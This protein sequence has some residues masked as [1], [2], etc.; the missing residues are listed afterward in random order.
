M[1]PK[2]CQRWW[3]R[4]LVLVFVPICAAQT[5]TPTLY[6]YGSLADVQYSPDGKLLITGS[7][8]G[9]MLWDA[10]KR[11]VIKRWDLPG[12]LETYNSLGSSTSVAFSPDGQHVA[13]AAGGTI[14]LWDA[15][16]TKLVKVYRA[17]RLRGSQ[18]PALLSLA[19]SPG[20]NVVAAGA[21][22]GRVRLW[23]VQDG[24]LEANLGNFPPNR[25]VYDVAFSPDGQL[26]AAASGLGPTGMISHIEAGAVRVWNVRTKKLIWGLEPQT[27]VFALTFSPDGE[28]LAFGTWDIKQRPPLRPSQDT[29]PRRTFPNSNGARLYSAR[30]GKLLTNYLGLQNPV[31]SLAFS[32]DGTLLAGSATTDRAVVWRVADGRIVA[33]PTGMYGAMQ[34]SALSWHPDGQTLAYGADMGVRFWNVLRNRLQARLPGYGPYARLLDISSDG[35]MLAVGSF[36]GLRMWHIPSGR[37]LREIGDDDFRAARFTPDGK[38]LL[39]VR[40]QGYQGQPSAKGRVFIERYDARRGERLASVET[41][42]EGARRAAFSPDRRFAAVAR[43]SFA[44][45]A[46]DE[47]V[48][49]VF[50]L[51]SG[52]RLASLAHVGRVRGNLLGR[53]IMVSALA[54]SHDGTRLA[55]S[56]VQGVIW[57]W[58]VPSGQLV[59]RLSVY[60]TAPDE[61][62][63]EAIA[64]HPEGTRLVVGAQ[65][66]DVASGNLLHTLHKQRVLGVYSV[67]WSADGRHV[68]I[69]REGSFADGLTIWRVDQGAKP[70]LIHKAALKYS[71]YS[72]RFGPYNS[73][74]LEHWLEGLI[75]R[76]TVLRG[77]DAL[78]R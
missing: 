23:N 77:R 28:T 53:P 21:T 20:G 74:F 14:K 13:A 52:K 43:D 72:A 76:R 25:H 29:R 41:D 65:I 18:P 35:Q 70:E 16:T 32:P 55:V 48:V 58:E 66:Y 2:G 39:V 71:V 60:K 34:D 40:E 26:L 45:P 78:G 3:L 62:G 59:K 68:L 19:F 12:A 54:F 63:T 46:N 61:Y 24:R 67:D 15:R 33:E 36:S 30:T 27:D 38:Q 8:R 57:L 5:S 50:A 47:G 37:L 42:I 75:G 17:K 51:F 10:A 31:R 69:A 1:K 11:Q 56:T 64:W 44:D 6:G 9:A 22:D 4:L 49:D 73:T 7:N